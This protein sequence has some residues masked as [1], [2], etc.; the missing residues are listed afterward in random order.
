MIASKEKDIP[1]NLLLASL[2]D[3]DYQRLAPHLTEV[4]LTLGQV[5]HE[6]HDTIETVY[7]PNQALISIV[8]TLEDGSSAEVGLIGNDGIW[9]YTVFLGGNTALG[10][11]IVQIEGSAYKLSASI[12]KAEF[13]RGGLLQKYLLRYTQAFLTQ[14]SQTALCNRFHPI[15]ERLARWLLLA[16]DYTYSDRLQLT[17]EFL[18]YMLGSRRASVTVAAGMLQQAGTIYYNRG[19]ITI[20]N[21]EALE[22]SACECYGTVKKEYKRI[23]DIHKK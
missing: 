12:L 6:P 18:S 4:F 22:A 1:V 14:V 16:Q 19:K 20:L 15:E 2:P 17:Q 8:H 13:E 9:G 23:L 21:R 5:L 10:R 11:A 7:F 3:S